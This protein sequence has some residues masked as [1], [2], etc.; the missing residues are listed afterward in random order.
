M[1]IVN[2]EKK[3]RTL[4]SELSKEELALAIADIQAQINVEQARR[5]GEFKIDTKITV[6][7]DAVVNDIAVTVG[8]DIQTKTVE[9]ATTNTDIDAEVDVK[10]NAGVRIETDKEF[11]RRVRF[12]AKVESFRARQAELEKEREL[13]KTNSLFKK[14]ISFR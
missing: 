2:V 8:V 7:E 14:L 3:K 1:K 10:V 13:A 5:R 4:L 6:N 11:G 12:N 9:V